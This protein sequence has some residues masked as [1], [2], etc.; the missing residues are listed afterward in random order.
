MA[1]TELW[2]GW[3]TTLRG[4][5]AD[6]PLRV[7]DDPA[8]TVERRDVVVGP[9]AF[10]WETL[11]SPNEPDSMTLTVWLVEDVSERATEKLLDQ[12]PALLGAIAETADS[13]VL[14]CEPAAF[15]AGGVSDLPSYLITIET[16]L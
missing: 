2:T 6:G 11:C 12:L 1:L 13:T 4:H 9:P 16:T 15:P 14:T 5:L 3:V 7:I 10:A 8:A